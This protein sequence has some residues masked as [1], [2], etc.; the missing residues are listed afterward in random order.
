MKKEKKFAVADRLTG[1]FDELALE[2]WANALY[3]RL[4]ND[5]T[6]GIVFMGPDFFEHSEEVLE[7]IRI[8][9]RIPILAGCSSHG[10][11]SNG[12]EFEQGGGITLILFHLPDAEI[13]AYHF[14]ANEIERANGPEFWPRITGINS[15]ETN[16]WLLLVD[17]F[18]LHSDQWLESWNL[19]YA[20]LPMLGGLAAGAIGEHQS[21]LFLNGETYSDGL[22]AVSVGGAVAIGCRISQGCTPIGDTWTITKAEKNLILEIANQSAFEVLSQT[23]SNLPEVVRERSKGNLFLGLVYDEYKEEFRRGDFLIRNLVGA[24]PK[25]G[26]IAAAAFPRA[27]QTVQFQ[28][29]DAHAADEDLIVSLEHAKS[30]LAGNKIYGGCLFSCRG[31]GQGL[32]GVPNHDATL[33]Q[34]KLGPFPLAGFFCNGE[35][36]PIGARSYLHGYTASLALFVEKK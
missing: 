20:P 12:I 36:G 18:H 11:I 6:F 27:G 30:D 17:P 24:D 28:L 10:L 19:A 31:R 29:R 3:D 9:A 2:K 35:I 25:S 5:V 22:I 32:F 8:N 7:I 34:E 15:L 21:Y 23:F 14:A 16:G 26:A 13:T 1:A 4:H 33:I